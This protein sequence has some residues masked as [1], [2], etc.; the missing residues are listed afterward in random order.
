[1]DPR[2]PRERR[3]IRDPKATR[4]S[5]ENM[6]FLEKKEQKVPRVML[7]KMEPMDKRAS[8]EKVSQDH[9]GPPDRPAR[10]A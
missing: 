10:R 7:E 4:E 9:P 5:P 6:V 2:V 1:L 3:A 8:Q